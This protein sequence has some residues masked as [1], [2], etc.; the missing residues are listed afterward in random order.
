MEYNV[1]SILVGRVV[2]F[3][4]RD[5]GVVL[6]ID[7]GVF[8]IRD[9]LGKSHLIHYRK[10]GLNRHRKISCLHYLYG[11]RCLCC[12]QEGPLTLDHVIREAVGGSGI[13]NLQLL[14]VGCNCRKDKT[15]IDYRPFHP[16]SLFSWLGD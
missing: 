4:D 9:V 13:E 15:T 6:G 7:E 8:D 12:G 14:C 3:T 1:G 2:P 5:L 16:R 11:S 10:L